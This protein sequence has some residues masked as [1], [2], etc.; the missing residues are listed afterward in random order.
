MT[1]ITKITLLT[2]SAFFL[3]NCSNT[4]ISQDSEASTTSVQSPFPGLDT[5]ATEDWW[6]RKDN[7]I[8]NMKVERNKVIAFG[9][10]T[11]SNQTLKLTAQLFPFSL[12]NPG[13]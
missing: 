9:I 4:P 13:K 12:M 2:L 5:L 7:E 6:N 10:Y 1:T 3:F 8:I 11:V